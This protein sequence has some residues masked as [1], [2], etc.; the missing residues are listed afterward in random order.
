MSKFRG[1]NRGKSARLDNMRD[2]IINHIRINR[3]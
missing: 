3:N 1:G 2:L